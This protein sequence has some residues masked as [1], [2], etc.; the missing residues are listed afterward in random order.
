MR[1]A[2]RQGR[3]WKCGC[4]L[5]KRNERIERAARWLEGERERWRRGE[6]SLSSAGTGAPVPWT[7]GAVLANSQPSPCSTTTSTHKQRQVRSNQRL[8]LP[9]VWQTNLE[10]NLRW[11]DKMK[12]EN[13]N[14][15]TLDRWWI[16]FLFKFALTWCKATVHSEV[17][18]PEFPVLWLGEKH[19]PF[20]YQNR[21]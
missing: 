14:I 4:R 13:Q 6:V 2:S 19:P 20:I 3:D 21:V 15:L 8:I 10:K 1:A 5:G 11:N 9:T 16:L 18:L 17:D 7:G 12:K